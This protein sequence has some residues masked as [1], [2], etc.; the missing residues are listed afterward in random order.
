MSKLRRVT[1]AQ[2]KPDSFPAFLS[3]PHHGA[4]IAGEGEVVKR[5]FPCG[6]TMPFTD[7]LRIHFI[8]FVAVG[9]PVII[10]PPLI[11]EPL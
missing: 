11:D 4:T 5:E 8:I 3:R 9:N 7:S 1:T 2:P 6:M 10:I